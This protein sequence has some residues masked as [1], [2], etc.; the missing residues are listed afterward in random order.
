M[1]I[2]PIRNLLLVKRDPPTEKTAGGI[3]VPEQAREKLTRGTVLAAGPGTLDT[4]GRFV[5]TELKKG[6]RIVFGKYSGNEM[7]HRGEQDQIFMTEDEVL[8]V[9]EEE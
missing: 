2:R 6:D 7:E 1:K 4:S 3:I 8:G 9:I 5:E